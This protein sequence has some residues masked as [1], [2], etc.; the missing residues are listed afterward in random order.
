MGYVDD[1]TVYVKSKSV[2]HL[3]EELERL[4]NKMVCYCNENGL[5]INSQKTQILTN[6]REKIEIKI[7]HD[8]VSSAPTI[9]L[10]GLEYDTNFSTA[11]YLR[12][13][14]RD[15]NT[16][17]ALIR[18]LSFGMPNCLLKP[19]SN[20]LLMGKILAAAT[21]A[22]PIRLCQNDKPY[23][24]GILNDIDKSIR[25]TARTI[26]QIKLTDKIRSEVILWKAG[27][28]SL[29]EAVSAT[30]A[31]TIWKARK[32][33]SPLG[34]IFQGKSSVKNTR[35]SGSDNLCQPVPGH[36]ELAAN[37]LAQVWNLMN[38]SNAKTLAS[39]KVSAR[40]WYKQNAKYL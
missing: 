32:E 9:S 20:G 33:M 4:A 11:P 29:T 7:N 26:T 14:A 23:L 10:L 34:C 35:S 36:P 3:R 38:L 25:A 28:R 40:E 27:L 19:L 8:V 21:A 30:M 1:T 39:A 16:R 37:K 15:A 12:Q 17:A 6:A 22:I 2:E 18:R 13:L 31:S 24:S 5:I